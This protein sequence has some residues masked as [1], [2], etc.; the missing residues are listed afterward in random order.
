MPKGETDLYERPRFVAQEALS[1]DRHLSRALDSHERGQVSNSALRSGLLTSLG[2]GVVCGA[3]V[4]AANAIS[5]RFRGALGISGKTALVVTPTLGAFSLSSHLAVGKAT[6]D[7][8]SYAE[9]AAAPVAV[10]AK[11]EK[12]G[13]LPLWCQLANTLYVHPFKT[14]LGT[15]GLS[16]G[17]LFYHESTSAATANMPLSQRLIH[18]RVYG[19][20]LVICITAAVMLFSRSMDEGGAYRLHEGQLKREA[21]I[22]RKLR[23]WYS[24]GGETRPSHPASQGAAGADPGLG[25]DLLMPLIYVPLLPLVV[26]GLRKRV[27]PDTLQKIAMGIIGTGLFHAGTI[28]FSDSSIVMD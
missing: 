27:A 19:Q 24:E 9:A 28:M 12:L 7:A 18:T 6:R 26:L 3:I 15:A 11:L 1:P 20:G 13:A 22:P 25:T 14:I 10:S 21:D 2:T 23:H 5:P 4:Y 8:A 16:Y 17:A